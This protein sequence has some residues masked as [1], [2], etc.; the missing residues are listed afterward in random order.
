MPLNVGIDVSKDYLEVAVSPDGP[1]Q[2]VPSTI[3]ELAR[4]A[5]RLAAV[6]P[7]RVLLEATGGYEKPFLRAADAADLPVVLVNPRR[8]RRF[9]QAMGVLA[10]TDRIDAKVLSLFGERVQPPIRKRCQPNELSEL[11]ARRRQ[12]ISMLVAEK[13]RFR[14]APKTLRQ[15]IQSLVRVLERR[16]ERIDEKMDRVVGRDEAMSRMRGTLQSVPS[17]GPGLVRTLLADMPELGSLDRREIAA[18]AGLAPIARDSGQK[19]GR[20][21]I[22]GGRASVRS[23][24]YM[25]AMNAARFNPVFRPFYERMVAAGKP[26]KVALVAIARRMLVILNAMAKSGT[27]W[28]PR[29][30]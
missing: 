30:T 3:L 18:L 1:V 24:L 29:L 16:V 14:M 10:K 15:E 25:A 17:V 8:T 22:A 21:V 20:R 26:P 6:C 5:K 13:N 7:E 28:S 2:R 23:A 27:A 11:A 4:L 19:H 9:A 12:L